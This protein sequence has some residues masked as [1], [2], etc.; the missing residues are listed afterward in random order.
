[1]PGPPKTPTSL[2]LLHGNPGKRPLNRHEPRPDPAS[3][4]CPRWLDR[5][6]REFWKLYAPRLMR[7][8]L[9]SELDEAKLAMAAERWST[10]RRAVA[11]TK[12]HLTQDSPS[13]GTAPKPEIAIARQA[14]N[15]LRLL[16]AEFGM[17][18]SSRASLET[19]PP[20]APTDPLEEFRARR[21]AR[22]TRQRL[23]DPA[24]GAD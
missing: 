23:T 17:S 10:Y 16:L 7:N 4:E 15:D 1:M 9:L 22:A 3:G 21:A 19:E 2:A 11:K 18:P 24:A 12:R 20:A 13:N 14:F 8:G 5:L 6:G